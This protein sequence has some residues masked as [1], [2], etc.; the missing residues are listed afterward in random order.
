MEEQDI[1]QPMS[2]RTIAYIV[3]AAS[4]LL[5]IGAAAIL[6][7]AN[8]SSLEYAGLDSSE[9]STEATGVAYAA[10]VAL[11]DDSD[12]EADADAEEARDESQDDDT[13]DSS[14]RTARSES[15]SQGSSQSNSSNNRSS[16]SGSGSSS[17]SSNS[18]SGQA[19]PG[20]SSSSSGSSSSS[21]SSGSSGGTSQS[22]APRTITV[23]IEIEARTAHASDPQAMPS[24]FSSGVLL[25]RRNV[26]VPE[27]ASVRQ[28]LDATG[29]RVNA[30]GAYIV[31]LGG[32]SEFDFGP[33]SGWMFSVNGSFPSSS[34]ANTTLNA[35]DTIAWRYTLNRGADIGAP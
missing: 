2:K 25:A 19:P 11:A 10:P 30:R 28:A 15:D 3:L 22:N 20:S 12:S 33:R 18:G 4:V 21:S 29:V 13:A 17:S 5:V 24:G 7:F 6:V 31:G 14:D 27:G 8:D 35:G 16:G 23:S 1:R 9:I 34:A 26:T 32:L